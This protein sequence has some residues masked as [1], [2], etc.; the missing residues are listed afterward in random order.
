M[1]ITNVVQRR[2]LPAPQNRVNFVTTV[3]LDPGHAGSRPGCY[4]GIRAAR[5][6]GT[7]NAETAHGCRHAG[8]CSPA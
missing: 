2:S 5:D 4:S 6:R 8:A 3:E 7:G 1:F